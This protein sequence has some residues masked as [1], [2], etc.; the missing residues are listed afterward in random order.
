MRNSLVSELIA[1]ALVE[2]H[3]YVGT[4]GEQGLFPTSRLRNGGNCR[5]RVVM[6]NTCQNLVAVGVAWQRHR[7]KL[8]NIQQFDAPPQL[9]VGH[10]TGDDAVASVAE[11]NNTVFVEFN[12]VNMH[13]VFFG[14]AIINPNSHAPHA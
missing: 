10:I 4:S 6:M 8:R 13:S 3:G 7:K 5:P 2:V 9:G 1:H 12:A 11:L 14:Q